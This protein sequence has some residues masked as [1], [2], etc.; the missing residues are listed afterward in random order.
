MGKHD[1]PGGGL[2][3]LGNGIGGRRFFNV[4]VDNSAQAIS[5]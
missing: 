5:L 4:L 2:R 1:R 3:R